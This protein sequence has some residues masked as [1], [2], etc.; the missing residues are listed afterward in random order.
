MLVAKL[1]SSSS[2]LYSHIVITSIV[3]F[4]RELK[5]EKKKNNKALN[6]VEI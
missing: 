1:L 4:T 3:N 5:N 6:K 2:A